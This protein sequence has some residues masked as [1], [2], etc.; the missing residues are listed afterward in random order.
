MVIANQIRGALEELPHPPAV[1]FVSADPAADTPGHVR[2]FLA[3]VG[4]SG[5]V[6]YLTGSQAKLAPIW[7]AYRIVPASAGTGGVRSLRL[8]ACCSIAV[9]A[10]A[11]C[12]GSNS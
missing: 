3:Q 4:L 12:T 5:R 6:H 1:V 11:W 10:R 7:R 8:G 9:V 2:R